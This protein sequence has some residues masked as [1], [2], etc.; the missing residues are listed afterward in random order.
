MSF[1]KNKKPGNNYKVSVSTT[2]KKVAKPLES[3]KAIELNSNKGLLKMMIKIKLRSVNRLLKSLTL[4][5]QVKTMMK[6]TII[7]C[8][9]VIGKLTMKTL[10]KDIQ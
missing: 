4:V 6:T 9:E 3:S 1:F 2:T 10:L 8:I 7:T 5:R